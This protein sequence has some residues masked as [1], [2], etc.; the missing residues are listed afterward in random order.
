MLFGTGSA[1][2][3]VSLP[4]PSR[5]HHEAFR[6]TEHWVPVR[7]AKG[8][9]GHH[10]T[11]ELTLADG[12]TLRARVS[13][14]GNNETYGK[15]T[16]S[17]ILRDQLAVSEPEFWACIQDG[18]LPTRW[19]RQVPTDAIPAGVV[20]RLISAVGL[21]ETEVASMP[22]QEAIDRPSRFHTTGN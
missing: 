11:Y 7:N 12:T 19:R 6:K 5:K 18:A 16:W 3:G 15:R 20:Y 9:T 22:K 2:T 14:P 4:T 8:K 13:H 1:R 10:I 17:H 21:A